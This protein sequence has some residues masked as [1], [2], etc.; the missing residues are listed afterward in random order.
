VNEGVCSTNWGPNLFVGVPGYSSLAFHKYGG[1][2]TSDGVTDTRQCVFLDDVMQGPACGPVM[3]GGA[4]NKNF[5]ARSAL[6]M[7]SGS[8][9][10]S[11]RNPTDLLVARITIWSCDTYK[12]SMCNGSSLVTRTTPN[13]QT[14][15]YYH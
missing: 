12:T 7:G 9:P 11:A 15:T 14:E 2:R 13:N 5:T 3:S 1:L 8:L 4:V 6:Y 10:G